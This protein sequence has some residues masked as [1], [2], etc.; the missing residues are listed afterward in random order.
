MTA[1]EAVRGYSTWS[2][3]ASF[4]EGKAGVIKAGRWADL[5]VMDVDPFV[6]ADESPGDIL[7]GQIVMTIVNGNIV[8]ER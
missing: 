2:A 5:T 4:R 7:D 8:Y 1:D 6:L 3:Y